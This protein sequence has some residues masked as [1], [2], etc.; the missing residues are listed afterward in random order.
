MFT[1]NLGSINTL[2]SSVNVTQIPYDQSQDGPYISL[3]MTVSER[4]CNTTISVLTDSDYMYIILY[5][6]ELS[7]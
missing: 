4:L 1:S 7:A 3:H 2:I 6:L 5:K